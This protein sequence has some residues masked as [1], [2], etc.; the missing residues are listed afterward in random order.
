MSND[1]MINM[2]NTPP[3]ELNSRWKRFR[4]LL[5]TYL[6]QANGAFVF[7]RINIFYFTGTFANGVFWLPKEG[8]PILFCRRGAE[9]AKME[10]PIR[11]IIPFTAYGD[12][13]GEI[14]QTFAEL[15]LTLPSP[16]AAEMNGLSWAL[17]KSLT[18][19]LPMIEFINADRLIAMTRAKKSEWELQILR[20]AG[21]KHDKCLTRLLPS[22]LHAGMN[23][24]E[25]SHKI[26]ELFFSEGHHGVLRMDAFGEEVFLGHIAIGDSANYPSVFNG[27]VG[28]RG[29]H[30]AAPFMGSEQ[31]KWSVGQP[32]T[33]DNGFTLAG[34]QTDKTQIYWLGG[35]K[36][37]PEALQSAHDFCVDMQAKIAEQLRPGAIPSQL[38]S[39]CRDLAGKSPWSDGFMGLGS[40]KVSFVGHGIGL[41]IDEYPVL[42]KGFDMPLEEGMV[43]AFEPKIGIPGV[44]MVGTEN[45]FE[46]TTTG[47]RSITGNNYEIITI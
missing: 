40:N 30:P 32:L 12:I 38:W 45:T 19:H 10:T 27:P 46:V 34:Y 18:K 47:G 41:A 39:Q 13:Q 21:E 7:S 37:I 5:Q 26:S 43:L 16:I 36:S 23:E 29:V 35:K 25:I 42:A 15:G 6:P 28:L 8:E 17:S 31:I 14:Q 44:G 24:L 1:N 11:K 4:D 33:I 9:R 20:Q 2:D 22:F 3:Q